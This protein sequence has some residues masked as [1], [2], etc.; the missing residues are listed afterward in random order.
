M[1]ELQFNPIPKKPELE[2][3]L[4]TK[5]SYQGCDCIGKHS[6]VSRQPWPKAT[7]REWLIRDTLIADS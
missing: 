7:L 5:R 2:V 4:M 3:K 6:A 1:S